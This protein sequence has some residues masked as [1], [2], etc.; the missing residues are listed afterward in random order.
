ML[1]LSNGILRLSLDE[2][3]RLTALENLK[4]GK[5]NIINQPAFLFRAIL[6]NGENWEDVACAQNAEA[7]VRLDGQQA[8]ISVA[9]LNTRMG[10]QEIAITLRLWLDGEQVHF[11]AEIANHSQTTVTDFFYPCIGEIRTLGEGKPGLLYPNYFGEYHTDICGELKGLS[12]WD[13]Q[14]VITIPYPYTLSMQWMTLIDGDQ[15]LYF[16]GRD[17]QF[18]ASFLRAVG[19]EE[20]GVTLEMNKLSFV[21]PGET[22]ECPEYVMW[23]YEGTWQQGA[24]E[25]RDWANSTWR[26]PVSPKKWIEDMNGYFLVINKQQFGDEMWPYDTIPELYERAKEHGCDTVGLFGW[27]HTGH[28]NMYPDLTVSPTLGGE[29]KLKAGIRAVQEQGGHVTLYYQGH[30]IDLNSPFYKDVGHRIAG[31]SIWGTPYYE[32]Y[33]KYSES[34]LL[35]RFSRKIFATVCPWCGEWHELMA[36]KADWVHSF[37]ADGILYDQIGGINPTPCFDKT[38]GHKKPSLSYTQ[39]R[40]KLLPAIRKSVDKYEEFAFMSENMTDLYSAH[41]DCVHGIGSWMGEKADRGSYRKAPRPMVIHMP[42]MYR[43]TFPDD[44]STVRNPKPYLEPRMVNYALT[45]GFRFEMEIRYAKDQAFVRENRKSEWKDYARQS[46]DLRMR[47]ADLLLKGTYSCDPALTKAN[48]CLEHGLFTCEDKR[49]LVLWNDTDEQLPI[50]LPGYEFTR[51]ESPVAK[52]DGVP[53]E[54]PANSLIVLF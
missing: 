8:V 13:S 31:K 27:F 46:A 11:G 32:E 10:R 14:H 16:S 39:G 44:L 2:Q 4:T 43:E 9:A 34:D 37:G 25:Y 20:G 17:D 6:K 23:L 35:R 36:K 18:Y 51:W 28:D 42:E 30:L 12:G 7:T 48:P 40:L 52:G 41:L 19:S 47:H 33:S 29:E 15:C 5:G 53:A 45:Y 38:H 54:I 26:H 1:E 49:C 22:W 21:E 50:S 3:G 24:A